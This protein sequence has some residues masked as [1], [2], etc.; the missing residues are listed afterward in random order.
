MSIFKIILFIFGIICFLID[1]FFLIF[2]RHYRSSNAIEILFYISLGLIYFMYLFML[3]MELPIKN[4]AINKFRRKCIS[5]CGICIIFVIFFLISLFEIII[6]SFMID[7]NSKYWKDC[8]FTIIEDYNLHFKRRCQL[9]NINDNSRFTNQ[10]ICSY[11]PYKD[12]KYKYKSTRKHTYKV[13]KKLKQKIEPDFIRCVKVN[14]LMSNNK[15]ITL[16]NN[17][18]KDII[19]IIVVEI[20]N[21]RKIH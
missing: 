19:N 4:N 15:I 10:Y 20:I 8:P 1:L 11:N 18:Y 12:F 6:L 2:Y 16:F 7:Y 13:P 5:P 9:Y 3:F 14:H 21:L 17:E